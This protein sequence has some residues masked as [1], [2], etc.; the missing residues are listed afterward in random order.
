MRPY[1]LIDK[2]NE[3]LS[4]IGSPNMADDPCLNCSLPICDDKD[5]ACAFVRI[6][7]TERKA[8]ITDETIRRRDYFRERYQARKAVRG[9]RAEI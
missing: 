9:D 8:P 7:P 6:V 5:A 3:R 2:L 4:L 1:K